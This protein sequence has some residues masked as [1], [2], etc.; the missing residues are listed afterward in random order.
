[1]VA[2]GVSV[3]ALVTYAILVL[4]K[5]YSVVLNPSELM[6]YTAVQGEVLH[7]GG[8]VE[9]NSLKRYKNQRIQ[10]QVTDAHHTVDV[11]FK[12]LLPGL[13]REGKGVV[14]TGYLDQHHVFHATQVLAK[15]DENYRPPS[16]K[17]EH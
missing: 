5:Q 12:G 3:S 6:H 11:K 13:F 14:L 9:K 2:L 16:I 10:F 4:L 7:L 8:L 15:H 1:M 17:S